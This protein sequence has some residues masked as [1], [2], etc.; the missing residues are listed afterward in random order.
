MS[1]GGNVELERRVGLVGGNDGG[2]KGCSDM[3]S[4]SMDRAPRYLQLI[5]QSFTSKLSK[6]V[7]RN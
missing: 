6:I 4:K 7:R 5:S 1:E 2:R 3:R